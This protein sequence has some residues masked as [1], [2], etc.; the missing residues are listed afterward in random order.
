M[1]RKLKEQGYLYRKFG[2]KVLNSTFGYTAS[3]SSIQELAD[4]EDSALGFSILQ[5]LTKSNLLSINE[6]NVLSEEDLFDL[7]E[8]LSAHVSKPALQP[9]YFMGL[10]WSEPLSLDRRE[11]I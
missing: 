2:K 1:F 5:E 9:E 10:G 7:I 4:I 6:D 3:L 8:F 11:R